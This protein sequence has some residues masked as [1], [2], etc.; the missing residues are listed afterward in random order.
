[1][2]SLEASRSVSKRVLAYPEGL[3]FPPPLIS[4]NLAEANKDSFGWYGQAFFHQL[5]KFLT[6]L[7]Q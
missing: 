5:S 7:V 1:M 6:E 3:P 2:A 4:F